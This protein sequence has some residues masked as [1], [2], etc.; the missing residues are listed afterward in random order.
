MKSESPLAHL[1]HRI[2]ALE[3]QIK[4]MDKVMV[5]LDTSLTTL[6]AMM[7]RE[8]QRTEAKR[9]RDLKATTPQLE[10]QIH[11]RRKTTH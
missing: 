6:I 4:A 5:K 2:K 9:Q 10:I 8:F 1:R 3:A 7:T 11:R